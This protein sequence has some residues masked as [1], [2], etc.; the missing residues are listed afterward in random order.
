MS[1]SQPF[2][3]TDLGTNQ[4]ETFRLNVAEDMKRVSTLKLVSSPI[5][6]LAKSGTRRNNENKFP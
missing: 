3:S 5:V 6:S 2:I 4:E 1:D